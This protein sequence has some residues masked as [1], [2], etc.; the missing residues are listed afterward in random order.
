MSKARPSELAK[1]PNRKRILLGIL[2]VVL[3]GATLIFAAVSNNQ[4][5]E[6]NAVPAPSPSE[7]EPICRAE[8]Q[9][10]AGFMSPQVDDAETNAMLE[11]MNTDAVTFGGRIVPA[12][13]EDPI[14]R[15][16]L[17]EARPQ[18]VVSSS[19]IS[20]VAARFPTVNARPWKLG[21]AA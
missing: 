18:Q 13:A 2:A 4:S 7:P 17:P 10:V 11:R 8:G 14:T 15:T 21:P 3:V 9:F 19:R 12:S 16:P 5:G 6:Q 20:I 1:T